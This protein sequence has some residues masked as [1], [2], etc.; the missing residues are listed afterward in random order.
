MLESLNKR[1]LDKVARFQ[2]FYIFNSMV[3]VLLQSL[4]P[5]LTKIAIRE[6][7]ETGF[8]KRK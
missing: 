2:K 5:L 3:F 1:Y 4:S 6:K 7:K 8:S